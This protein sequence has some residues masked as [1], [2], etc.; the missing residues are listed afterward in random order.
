[1]QDFKAL[2][3]V[4]PAWLDMGFDFSDILS[5]DGERAGLAWALAFRAA[6]HEIVVLPPPTCISCLAWLGLEGDEPGLRAIALARNAE[7]DPVYMPCVCVCVCVCCAAG[8]VPIFQGEE[9]DEVATVPAFEAPAVAPPAPA[10]PTPGR[11]RSAPSA[12]ACVAATA[13]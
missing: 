3:D 11:K 13:A 1:M 4:D 12:A 10:A 2:G 5:D 7:A 6:P 8:R 9:L